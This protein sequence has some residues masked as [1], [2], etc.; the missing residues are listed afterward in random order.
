CA[1]DVAGSGLDFW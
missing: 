1:R